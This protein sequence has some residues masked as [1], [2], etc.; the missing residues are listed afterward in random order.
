L[1]GFSFSWTRTLSVTKAVCGTVSIFNSAL[2]SS[3]V[4]NFSA[5][6]GEEKLHFIVEDRDFIE[7]TQSHHHFTSRATK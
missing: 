7:I 5:E 1:S 4:F 2:T 6:E 3:L